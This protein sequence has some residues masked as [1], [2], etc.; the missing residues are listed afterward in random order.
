VNLITVVARENTDTTSRRTIVVRKDAAD[1]AI[2]KTPK[3][4]D[5]V[6]DGAPDDGDD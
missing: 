4:D 5:P 6:N 1:G 2:L 3:T